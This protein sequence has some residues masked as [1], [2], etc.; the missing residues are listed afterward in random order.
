MK[1]LTSLLISVLLLSFT[2]WGCGGSSTEPND[3][4]NGGAVNDDPSFAA[5]IQPILT[6]NCAIPFCH[7]NNN[8]TGTGLVLTADS[9]YIKLVAV[10][11]TE[12]PALERVDPGDAA[13]SYLVHKI[14]GT[15]SVGQRMPLGSSTPL[16]PDQIQLI[17]NWINQGAKDN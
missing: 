13:N 14:E 8:S 1:T 17:R 7:D 11:S 9:A 15:Q 5:E 16:S 2:L 12:V 10:S 4:G 6:A 3:G